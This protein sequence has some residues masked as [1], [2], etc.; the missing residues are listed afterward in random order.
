MDKSKLVEVLK[1][2]SK[3][4]FKEFGKYLEGT[5]YRKGGGIFKLYAYLKK[6][7]PDFPP[8]K[9]TKEQ[10][11]KKLFKEEKNAGKRM[12]DFMYN[13]YQVLEEFLLKKELE[14]NP[15]ER[16]FLML[17]ILK[18]R[19]LDRMFF[20]RISHIQKDWE[21]NTPMGIEQLYN[22]YKLA[23]TCY[24][25]PNY[26]TIPG[27][28]IDSL[29]LLDKIDKHYFVVKLYYNLC[30][31]LNQYSV[32]LQDEDFKDTRKLINSVLE[33][34]EQE[35]YQGIPQIA[36]FS[37][38]L[39]AY[40]NKNFD[41][42][43]SCKQEFFETLSLYKA[44]ES[45]DLFLFLQHSAY[46]NYKLGKKE[47]L[48]EFFEL[49]KFALEQA[50]FIDNGYMT[51]FTFKN[52]VL[53]AC[54][55]NE[56][57]WT[58]TFIN[59]YQKCLDPS[60]K[61]DV[62]QLCKAILEFNRGAFEQSLQHIAMVKLPDAVYG[63][64]LRCLQLQCYYELEDYE[65]LFFNMIK[66]FGTYLSRNNKLS[67]TYKEAWQNFIKY[68]NKL[69]IQESKLNDIPAR[70]KLHKEIGEHTNVSTK[71]WLMEKASHLLGKKQVG[72]F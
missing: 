45:H 55:V 33:S 9:I 3:T 13:M 46:E 32:N 59:D 49:N 66:S 38:L 70:Q 26:S 48:R 37:K 18:K 64:Q 14:E 39:K 2:L 31:E 4:E 57:E 34:C 28:E 36:L 7:H 47:Y 25:H 50:I 51:N 24:M 44:S 42:Y 22:E 17:E 21:K 40:H 53:V 65:E 30:V 20:Q 16:E 35:V 62:I 29:V 69:K 60:V 58:A 8:S 23:K 1:T 6:Y 52:I 71:S 19:Q 10:V 41:N 54:A 15:I 11:Y 72:Q 56:L 43:M 12:M 63:V 5:S 61:E 67:E 68:A 27:S